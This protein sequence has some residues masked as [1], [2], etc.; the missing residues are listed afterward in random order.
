MFANL[1]ARKLLN[2]GR[3]LEG[4][5]FDELVAQAPAQMQEALARGSDS[6][7]VVDDTGD[8]AAAGE[9]QVYHLA[10]RQFRLNGRSHDLLLLRQLTTE[11]R[12]QEVQTWKKVIRVISP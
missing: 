11:L 9:E 8:A 2:S 3:K 1:V 10:R 6:L 5:R 4:R 7:F 12:R